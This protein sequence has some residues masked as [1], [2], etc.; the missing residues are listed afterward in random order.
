MELMQD[1][2]TVSR[3]NSVRQVASP[4]RQISRA[5]LS[6]QLSSTGPWQMKIEGNCLVGK[7]P[8][9][10]WPRCSWKNQN[11]LVLDEPTN[12]LDIETIA[13]VWKNCLVNYS[14]ALLIVSHDR[15]FLDKIATITLD[16]TSIL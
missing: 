12:H 15:Y 13:A 8:V 1:Y 6:K 3:K 16:L 9:S 7:I 14:G 11:L 5:I 4:R 10:L 2:L